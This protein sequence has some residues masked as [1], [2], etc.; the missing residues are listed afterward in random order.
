MRALRQRDPRQEDAKHLAF[1]RAQPCCVCG[2]RRNVE[3][4]HLRMACPAIGKES[5]GMQ[6]KPHDMW[7]T[8]LCNYHHQSGPIA[9]HKVGEEQF[10]IDRGLNPFAIAMALWEQSGGAAR[11][12]AGRPALRLRPVKARKP[13]GQRAKIISSRRS[14]AS[15]KMDGT[16]ISRVSKT[17]DRLRAG[18]HGYFETY[19]AASS[20]GVACEREGSDFEPAFPA[21]TQPGQLRSSAQKRLNHT[22]LTRHSTCSSSLPSPDHAG[23]RLTAD[24]GK[25]LPEHSEADSQRSA[26]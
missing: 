5:T 26:P 4:A 10:W 21:A 18:L 13:R 15:R 12:R 24:C 20:H 11:A 14:I 25:R 7:T 19:E 17:T 23:P 3:A 6:Q 16:P 1:V 9:Q 8:P 22:Q 2:S